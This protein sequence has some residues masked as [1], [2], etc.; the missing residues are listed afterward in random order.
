M[1]QVGYLQGSYQDGRSIKHKI[2]LV[3]SWTV[4]PLNFGP[5]VCPATLVQNNDVPLRSIPEEHRSH[6]HAQYVI[7][8]MRPGF[9]RE[10]KL[11]NN[12]YAY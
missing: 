3:A 4:W 5:T 1:R 7:S 2:N 10:T 8:D 12:N 9:E 11:R 6:L